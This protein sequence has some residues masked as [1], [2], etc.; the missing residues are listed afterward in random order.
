MLHQLALLVPSTEI[1]IGIVLWTLTNVA[2]TVTAIAATVGE[3]SKVL[4]NSDITLSSKH[5]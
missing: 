2:S 3:T 4:Q 1:T 5:L